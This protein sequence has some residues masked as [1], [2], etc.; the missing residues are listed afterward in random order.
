MFKS[1]WFCAC[2]ALWLSAMPA[3]AVTEAQFMPALHVFLQATDGDDAAIEPAAEAFS[4]LSQSEPGNAVLL[5][6]RGAATAMLAKTMWMPWK[7][8]RQAEDGLAMLDKSLAMLATASQPKLSPSGAATALEV[9]Y[10]AARTFLAVPTVMHRHEQGMRLLAQVQAHPQL[11]AAP[12][13]LR[14]RVRQTAKQYGVG[15]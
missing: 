3:H 9:Q 7:K 14:E 1:L 6:Y 12:T 2:C 5:A 10:V 13:I 8:M 4:A 11:A 15:L